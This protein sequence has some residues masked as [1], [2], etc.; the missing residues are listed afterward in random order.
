MALD[1]LAALLREQVKSSRLY[2]ECFAID[3]RTLC[4]QQ[5]RG[6]G[7]RIHPKTALVWCPIPVVGT[8]R[9][10][11]ITQDTLLRGATSR[12]SQVR[13]CRPFHLF[14]G[15]I[16]RGGAAL[17]ALSDDQG[18]SSRACTPKLSRNAQKPGGV[19]SGAGEFCRPFKDVLRVLVDA[20]VL[21]NKKYP[22]L[23]RQSSETLWRSLRPEQAVFSTTGLGC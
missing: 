19:V 17:E 4:F 9:S 1:D 20:A 7:P 2:Q 11:G 23:S 16:G 18:V 21:S 6:R 12:L 13:L 5:Q 10:D 22:V 3:V 14:L 8:R 15:K